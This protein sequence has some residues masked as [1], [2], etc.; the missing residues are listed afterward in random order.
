[1]RVLVYNL[2]TLGFALAAGA[3]IARADWW[4]ALVCVAGAVVFL[5]LAMDEVRRRA[6]AEFEDVSFRAFIGARRG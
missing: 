2:T 1:V 5:A 6:L 4:F 3:Q